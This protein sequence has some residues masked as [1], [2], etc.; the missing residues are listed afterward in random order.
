[1][2]QNEK[3]L[4]RFHAKLTKI[5]KE[6]GALTKSDEELEQILSSVAKFQDQLK[7]H[8]PLNSEQ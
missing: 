5:L 4:L 1:M 6:M 3:S 7:V 2:K 8:N